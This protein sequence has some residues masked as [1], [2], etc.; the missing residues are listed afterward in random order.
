MRRL[1]EKGWRLRQGLLN[2][3]YR[4]RTWNKGCVPRRPGEKLLEGMK[5]SLGHLEVKVGKERCKDANAV[6]FKGGPK[7]GASPKGT[8][9]M[10]NERS[11]GH[12]VQP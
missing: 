10:T 4:C 7:N 6:T 5:T 8:G 9:R 1:R 11:I 3:Q 12:H 2:K